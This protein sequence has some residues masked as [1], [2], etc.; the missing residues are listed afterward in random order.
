MK[1]NHSTGD[2]NVANEHSATTVNSPPQSQYTRAG[3]ALSL[4]G[5]PDPP[6]LDLQASTVTSVCRYCLDDKAKQWAAHLA[7]DPAYFDFHPALRNFI[8]L[9]F[10]HGESMADQEVCI[11]S[12]VACA[13]NIQP[14]SPEPPRAT[15]FTLAC[16]KGLCWVTKYCCYSNVWS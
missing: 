11:F 4:R 6:A 3:M 8:W 9:P 13:V 10:M 1:A 7:S 16:L 2:S 15:T 14:S 5:T 12:Q